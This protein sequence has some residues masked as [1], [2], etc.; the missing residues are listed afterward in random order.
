MSRDRG[1]LLAE[2]FPLSARWSPGD[3]SY[4]PL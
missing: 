2:R 3:E 4:G 1:A